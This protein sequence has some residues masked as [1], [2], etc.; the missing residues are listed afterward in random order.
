MLLFFFLL[1]FRGLQCGN[2]TKQ[3]LRL[4][5]KYT[6]Y[7]AIQL[8]TEYNHELG[9]KLLNKLVGIIT[10]DY[11]ILLAVTAFICVPP[12]WLFYRRESEH[13]L[14]TIA[15]FL[16]VFPFVLYFSG[17]RQAIT[18][19]LGVPAWYCAKN[20]KFFAFICVVM[21]AML[22]HT[23]AF[24]L[25]VIYP[26]YYTRIT[27]KWLWFVIPCM[28]LI[29][30][31]RVPIFNFLIT[32]LW[33][34]YDQTATTGATTILILLVL[35]GV[36]AYILP[37]EKDLDPDAIAMRNI[38]LLSIVLQFFAML[39]PLA[40][41]MNYYFLLFVPVLIPK[42]AKQSK[43]QFKQ[44]SKLSVIVMTVYFLYYFVDTIITDND[45]LN[46]FPYIP[47]WRNG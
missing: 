31:F 18:I 17:I 43:K 36:Y 38:L 26:L 23:S 41:R 42:I 4:F 33:K 24:M 8:F 10:N 32:L 15:L 19:S 1:A 25:M 45:P 21:L 16:T 37:N 2:D 7:N 11:Q 28:A 13:Q 29:F 30:V 39:H 5:N 27:K 3:Y 46:I 40:M 22:F 44:I 20:K 47:F 35:F 6:A 34:E 14:L 9:Y 12:L